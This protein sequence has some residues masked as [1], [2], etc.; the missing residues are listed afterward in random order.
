MYGFMYSQNLEP[1][2]AR[3]TW[4]IFKSEINLD[5]DLPGAIISSCPHFSSEYQTISTLMAEKNLC[6]YMNID[7]IFFM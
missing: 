2:N 6:V 3:K 1:T 5:L 7:Y 4:T